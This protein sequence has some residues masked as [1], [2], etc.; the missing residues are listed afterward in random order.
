M[1]LCLCLRA[2]TVSI[3]TKAFLFSVEPVQRISDS[4]NCNIKCMGSELWT[5]PLSHMKHQV[6]NVQSVPE[7]LSFQLCYE[8]NS[9]S[10]SL[11]R[12]QG[13]WGLSCP[14]LHRGAVWSSCLKGNV[15]HLVSR[16][17]SDSQPLVRRRIN[18]IFLILI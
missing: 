11:Q 5:V 12:N 10:L 9:S 16:G 15:L 1:F 18:G 6:C 3:H 13:T 14:S 7:C 8:Y 17:T 2:C 4:K